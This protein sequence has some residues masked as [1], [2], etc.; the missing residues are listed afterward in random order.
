MAERKIVYL[1]VERGM[2][3]NKQTFWRNAGVAYECR[4]GSFNIKLDI[5]PNLT[6]NM[7]DP[8]SIGETAEI[9]QSL[10]EADGNVFPCS[11]CT[12]A[13]DT[14]EAHLLSGGGAVCQRCFQQKYKDCG[15]CGNAFPKA[16]D[17]LICPMCK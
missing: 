17:G 3:P 9:E 7:R 5:H 1:L 4:D 10:D 14:S 6:F 12:I 11:A 13:T 16:I 2:P 15:E 8:K